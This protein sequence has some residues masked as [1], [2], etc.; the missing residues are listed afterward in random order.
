MTRGKNICKILKEI[1]GKIAEAI[2]I[3]CMTTEC[4]YKGDCSG[5]CPK[6]EAEVRYLEHQLSNRSRA[7]KIVKLAGILA[8][9]LSMLI[10]VASDAHAATDVEMHRADSVSIPSR[11]PILIEGVVKGESKCDGDS[12]I[13]EVLPGATIRNLRNENGVVANIDGEFEIEVNSGDSLQ[14]SYVGYET[15]V[16]KVNEASESLT[17]ILEDYASQDSLFEVTIV[18]II[19]I[20]AP[21]EMLE[22]YF[23]DEDGNP[24]DPLDV[25]I[26]KITIDEDGDEDEDWVYPTCYAGSARIFWNEDDEFL[27]EDKRPLKTVTLRFEAYDYDEPVTKKFKYSKKNTKKT[28]RFKH[29]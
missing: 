2:D 20:Y 25:R 24:I 4:C 15:K 3:E 19:R 23:I 8:A 6:G 12:T 17:V 18:D 29:K 9:F 14:F 16:I 11:N 10:P 27:D 1:R 26:Y 7:G 21:N 22:L 13:V 5:T 28:I